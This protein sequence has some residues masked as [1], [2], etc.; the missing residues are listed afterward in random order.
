MSSYRKVPRVHSLDYVFETFEKDGETYT[1]TASFDLPQEERTCVDGFDGQA[2]PRVEVAASSTEI[3]R[4]WFFG[5]R[6]VLPAGVNAEI[7][8]R[9]REAMTAEHEYMVWRGI[10]PVPQAAVASHRAVDPDISV[11]DVRRAMAVYARMA[12]ETSTASTRTA[13]WIAR[14][15]VARQEHEDAVAQAVDEAT[16]DL[17]TLRPVEEEDR[18]RFIRQDHAALQGAIEALRASG[19]GILEFRA[20]TNDVE[21]VL[22]YLDDAVA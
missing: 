14:N 22:D 10:T 3:V 16:D 5:G 11:S 13:I 7:E 20:G 4:H 9:V 15:F 19:A 12:A 1:V 6:S 18:D 17:P 2:I 21:K 8:L